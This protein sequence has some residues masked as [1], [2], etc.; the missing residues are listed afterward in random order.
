MRIGLIELAANERGY[1]AAYLSS[2][3]TDY[4]LWLGYRVHTLHTIKD[5]P[6]EKENTVYLITKE[7]A[8]LQ[9]LFF[10]KHV[11]LLLEHAGINCCLNLTGHY[12]KKIKQA[13]I[14]ALQ[15]IHLLVPEKHS[16]FSRLY[17]SKKENT[18]QKFPAGMQALAY[19]ETVKE[20]CCTLQPS[21]S[22]QVVPFTASPE[23][24]ELEWPDKILVKAQ[25]A[26]NKEYFLCMGDVAEAEFIEIIKGFSKFKKWQQSSM[27]LVL[28]LD[29]TAWLETFMEKLKSYRYKDDLV[30]IQEIN[31]TQLAGLFASAYGFLHASLT[32]ENLEPIVSSLQC[33]V[34]LICMDLPAYREYAGE[35]A[36]YMES[37]TL[38][39]VSKHL[40]GLYKNENYKSQMAA[41]ARTAVVR[42]QRETEKVNLWKILETQSNPAGEQ[43]DL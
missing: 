34:P 19:A 40:I 17:S 32:A 43:H 20:T 4:A 37:L 7:Q 30:I 35:S 21:V 2:L 1:Y 31:E 14:F 12:F 13:Q 8:G 41:H 38:T 24:K 27:Q 5:I 10:E 28:V 23:M 3:L 6:V 16:F 42:Y 22:I 11:R 26:G 9:P 29:D 33:A 15:D 18:L 39:E 36:L 25:Y